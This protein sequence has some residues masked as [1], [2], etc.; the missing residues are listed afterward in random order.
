MFTEGILIAQLL[1]ERS[2][3]IAMDDTAR[4]AK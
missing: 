3:R 4:R 1:L 2:R